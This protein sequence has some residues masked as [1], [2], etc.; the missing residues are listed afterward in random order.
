MGAIGMK[1]L[2][3]DQRCVCA[4]CK[5]E[6]ARIGTPRNATC[7]RCG[8]L[9]VV[10]NWQGRQPLAIARCPSCEERVRLAYESAPVEQEEK[11]PSHAA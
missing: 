7:T 11:E 3:V 5:T 9:L 1:R 8:A 4:S 2:E 10:L 6:N